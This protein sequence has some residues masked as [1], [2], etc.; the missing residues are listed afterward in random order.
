[1]KWHE[2]PAV[3]RRLLWLRVTTGGVLFLLFLGFWHAQVIKFREFSEMALTNSLRALDLPAP[4]GLLR[5]RRGEVL[6]DTAPIFHLLLDRE[7]SASPATTLERVSAILDISESV[8]RERLRRYDAVPSFRPVPIA[9]NISFAQM[10]HFAARAAE[11]PDLAI[12]AVD[13]RRYPRG[14]LM[15]HTLGHVGEITRRQLDDRGAFPDAQQG[16]IVGQ[17]G[18]EALSDALLRGRR[19]T[20]RVIVDSVGRE[21]RMLGKTLPEPGNE[22]QLTLD[23]HLAQVL[24]EAFGE[25]HGAAVALNPQT[26]AVLALLSFPSFDPNDFALRFSEEAWRALSENPLRPLHNRAIAGLYAPGST[27]KIVNATAALEADVV[28]PR[29][30][31]SCR[32][33]AY[34]YRQLF[35]CW[36]LEGHGA[37]DMHRAMVHSCNVYFYH[38]G[39]KVGIEALAECASRLGLAGKAGLALPG[40]KPGIIPSPD[41]KRKNLGEDWYDGETISVAIGQGPIAVSPLAQAVMVSAVANGGFLVTPYLVEEVRSPS[42]KRLEKSAPPRRLRALDEEVAERLRRM[43]WGVVNEGGTGWRARIEGLDVCGKTGTAQVVAKRHL[44][45]EEEEEALKTHSWFLGFAP[46]EHPEV[47]LAVL[48]EHGGFGGETA[49]PIAKRFFEAYRAGR[50]PGYAST[51]R[52]RP[53]EESHA[54]A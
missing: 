54:G 8:L 12:Q 16:D 19:G 2:Q 13:A 14:P 21:V 48:V 10:A 47:A 50:G 39:K 36:K 26:G 38:L 41:W 3:E 20:S 42:G 44:S 1:M 51:E 25:H 31:F 4:R 52:D 32:G 17:M 35:E 37:L 11:F 45:G 46:L 49:A 5:D 6:A 9:E 53:D 28:S 22:L 23:A 33:G 40:E 7:R 29:R 43:L 34:F 24:Q 27:F 18:V 30:T 15:A